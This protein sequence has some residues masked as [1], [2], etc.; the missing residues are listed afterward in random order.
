MTHIISH[1]TYHPYS[2]LYPPW[3]ERGGGCGGVVGDVDEGGEVTS[4][5]ARAR[6][7][8]AQAGPSAASRPRR[9]LTARARSGAQPRVRADQLVEERLLRALRQQRH[10]ARRRPTSAAPTSTAPAAPAAALRERLQQRVDALLGH[11]WLVDMYDSEERQKSTIGKARCLQK[12]QVGRG[13]GGEG[14]PTRGRTGGARG[15]GGGATRGA[16]GAGAMLTPTSSSSAERGRSAATGA[17]ARGGPAAAPPRG[18]GPRPPAAAEPPGGPSRWVGARQEAEQLP[19]LRHREG[20]NVNAEGIVGAVRGVRGWA[21]VEIAHS[22]Q[23]RSRSNSSATTARRPKRPAAG[24]CQTGKS[25]RLSALA[26]CSSPALQNS[27]RHCPSQKT[28]EDGLSRS[29]SS[30]RTVP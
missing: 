22:G 27:G 8:R 21:W 9:A 18:V 16:H 28:D 2:V 29:S 1:E 14:A 4:D 15:L 26:Y 17:L 13:R 11:A 25:V 12:S 7:A 19:F 23:G 30:Y 10:P 20:E 24:T 3:E 6:A 5:A